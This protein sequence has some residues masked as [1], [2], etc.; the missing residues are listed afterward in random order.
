[1]A[2]ALVVGARPRAKDGSLLTA[3]RSDSTLYRL[4][5]TVGDGL[6]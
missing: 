2:W 5:G 4:K 3:I 6:D 1:M